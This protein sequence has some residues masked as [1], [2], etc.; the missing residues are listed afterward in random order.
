M[1]LSRKNKWLYRTGGAMAIVAALAVGGTAAVGATTTSSQPPSQRAGSQQTTGGRHGPPLPLGT[2][3]AVTST[4]LTI[5]DP[6]GTSHTIDLTGSTTY[7]K[8]GNSASASDVT[9]G[10]YVVIQPAR[11]STPPA[12]GQ[13]PSGPI[14][15]TAVH[16]VASLPSPPQGAGQGGPQGQSGSSQGAGEGGPQSQSGSSQGA[17]TQAAPTNANA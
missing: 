7:T 16:I 14:V 5:T 13:M 10:E 9:T 4:T 11:P 1:R 17:P 15:A 12:Q 8:D 6:K 2:V 3:S